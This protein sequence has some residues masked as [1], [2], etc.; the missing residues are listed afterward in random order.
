MLQRECLACVPQALSRRRAQTDKA[1]ALLE[2]HLRGLGKD[3]TLLE[4]AILQDLVSMM[5]Y[6]IAPGGEVSSSMREE[7]RVAALVLGLHR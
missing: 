2:A 5:V 3:E 6:A 7:A 1:L 4:L